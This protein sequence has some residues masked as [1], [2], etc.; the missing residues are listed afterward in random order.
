MIVKK[1]KIKK[2]SI[3][4]T[5]SARISTMRIKPSKLIRKLKKNPILMLR[6][7]L[8]PISIANLER[9]FLRISEG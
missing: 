6:P 1:S 4:E 5:T 8:H 7:F 9:D 2:A 3:K